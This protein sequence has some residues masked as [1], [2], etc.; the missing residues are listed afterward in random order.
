MTLRIGVCGSQQEMDL[1]DRMVGAILQKGK[2]RVREGDD[3]REGE[4]LKSHSLSPF[5]LSWGLW[6]Q[7]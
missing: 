5:P 6:A 3:L 4:V 1:L 7:G 2:P